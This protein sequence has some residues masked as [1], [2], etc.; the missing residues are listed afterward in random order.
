M[1]PERLRRSPAIKPNRATMQPERLRRSP[2]I[3]PN[4]AT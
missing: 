4:R 3:K 2:A 1:Q